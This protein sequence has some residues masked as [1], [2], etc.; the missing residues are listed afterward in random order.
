[1]TDAYLNG[2]WITG[3][4]SVGVDDF[5]F[6]MGVT[7]TERLRTFQGQLWRQ[8]EHVARMRRSAVIVGIS[9]ESIDE[10]DHA[11][12]E[13]E[14]RLA[15]HRR[16]EEDWSVVAFATPGDGGA[17][18]RCVHG[19]PLRFAEWALLY[20]N[21]QRLR[22]SL[23]RQT[24]PNCWP[25]E[26][27]CRSRMH[28]Y[29]ADREAAAVEPGARALLLDQEGYVGEATTANV[30]AYTES[31]GIVSPL[32]DKVLPGVSVAVLRELAEGLGVAFTERDI[33]VEQLSQADEVWLSSTSICLIPVTHLD[34]RPIGAG[35]PGPAY[36]QMLKAWNE[37]VGLN[38]AAQAV[39][40]SST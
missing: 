12:T 18:T 36:R 11:L 40:C 21:G 25:P 31:E 15:T 10:I 3:P 1:M 28:Y 26:L 37:A 4:I 23:H 19:H 20:G 34:G 2:E 27:K 33:T 32:L 9:Q 29:L 16:P 39:A 6:T 35:V 7:I 38:I 22:L 24:P 14:A 8:A 30:V 13:Y 5:G 17:P